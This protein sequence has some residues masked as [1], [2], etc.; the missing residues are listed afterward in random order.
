[1]KRSLLSL[2]AVALLAMPVGAQDIGATNPGGVY[3]RLFGGATLPTGNFG[4]L[5][6]TGWRGG[7]TIGWQLAGIPV[8]FDLDV[9]YDRVSGGDFDIFELGD[10][11]V[12]SGTANIRWD[13]QGESS[14]GFYVAGGGGIYHFASYDVDGGLALDRR[15]RLG[16]GYEG[17]SDSQNKFGLNGGAGLTFGRSNTRFFVEARY[18]SVFTDGENA[19]FIPI[20]VGVQFGPPR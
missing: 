1:M 8:G 6:D 19:N 7:G 2:A 14:I 15:L 10:L 18:H 12:T 16:Q 11:G 3:F 17:E 9:A 4:D 20:V 5:F 13:Y